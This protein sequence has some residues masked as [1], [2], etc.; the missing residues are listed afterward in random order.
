MR[1]MR[2]YHMA[3]AGARPF[4]KKRATMQ[5]KAI[6]PQMTS[7]MS[8]GRRKLFGCLP[9]ARMMAFIQVSSAGQFC[10]PARLT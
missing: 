1:S 9:E 10:E 3:L 7:L 8:P 5:R 2:P 6:V 4:Q